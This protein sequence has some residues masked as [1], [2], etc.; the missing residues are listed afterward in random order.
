MKLHW[1]R[2][3]AWSVS[4]CCAFALFC[5]PAAA[6]SLAAPA[7][8]FVSDNA[9]VLSDATKSTI[10]E[11]AGALDDACGAQIVVV[12]V[13]DTEGLSLEQYS[14]ELFNDW[15]IGDSS[16]NNGVLLLLD[17]AGDDYQC[18]QG[19]GLE[20]TLPT[21]R[22]SSILQE[23]LEPDF[24]AK[25]Y[26]AGVLKTFNAL[27]DEVCGIYGVSPSIGSAGAAQSGLHTVPGYG[28]TQNQ[29]D[30]P[31][32]EPDDSYEDYG[33]GISFLGGIVRFVIFLVF[34]LVLISVLSSLVRPRRYGAG[35]SG[36]LPFLLGLNC[37]PY[38]NYPYYRGRRGPPPPT[39]HPDNFNGGFSG[40]GLFGNGFGGGSSSG[41]H[42]FGGGHSSFGGGHSGGFSGGG[43]SFGGGGTRGGGAGRGH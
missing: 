6:V 36:A 7:E 34:I 13:N 1:K 20:T 11:K 32:E 33:S 25:N 39:Y 15:G 27:Y 8:V 26:D 12:T 2:I 10:L 9:S 19:S 4:L 5:L 43:H 38:R 29:T 42:S 30:N 14:Y 31:Y 41:G 17:I 3:A 21:S 23:D 40:G 22:L 35:G 16:K 18:V 24:A 28:S 37:R